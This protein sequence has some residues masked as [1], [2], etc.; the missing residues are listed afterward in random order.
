MNLAVRVAHDSSRL[1][2]KFAHLCITTLCL[3]DNGSIGEIQMVDG[4][5]LIY[6]IE[7]KV[8]VIDVEGNNFDCYL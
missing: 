6:M 4:G 1:C 7:T 5:F 3:F 2:V 8:K